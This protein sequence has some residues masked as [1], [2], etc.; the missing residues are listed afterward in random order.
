M[1]WVMYAWGRM[2][3]ADEQPAATS[4]IMNNESN[5]SLP[6]HAL[7]DLPVLPDPPQS[8]GSL[9]PAYQ[10]RPSSSLGSYAST[11]DVSGMPSTGLSRAGSSS[12]IPG[13]GYP[14]PN[15]QASE[16]ASGPGLS[17]G[18]TERDGRV[19]SG[20]RSIR[21]KMKSPVEGGDSSESEDDG[22]GAD[23]DVFG[24]GDD[25]EETGPR[26]GPL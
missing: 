6:S 3:R 21:A 15:L 12:R 22:L 1:G 16:T 14:F 5:E 9:H 7:S 2:E 18:T 10:D 25:A 11:P 8:G 4:F 19:A 17:R 26:A 20:R 24:I 23:R 13:E